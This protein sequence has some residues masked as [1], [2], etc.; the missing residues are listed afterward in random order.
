[1]KLFLWSL[2][3]FVALIEWTVPRVGAT[4]P[5]LPN[6]VHVSS[7]YVIGPTET[8]SYVNSTA[9]P[10]TVF[11]PHTNSTPPGVSRSISV[12]DEGQ[13]TVINN[14]TVLAEDEDIILGYGRSVVFTGNFLGMN[15]V[16]N[17]LG[18]SVWMRWTIN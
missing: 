4:G 1:M 13:Y 9:G 15:Y 17:P 5:N 12:Q 8:S 16:S 7:N 18:G 3:L 14:V 2:L 11:L 10:F 6:C